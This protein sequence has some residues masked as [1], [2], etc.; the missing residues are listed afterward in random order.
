MRNPSCNGRYRRGRTF[1]KEKG[2]KYSSELTEN[3]LEGKKNFKRKKGGK[4]NSFL[5][6]ERGRVIDCQCVKVNLG[7]GLTMKEGLLRERGGE[8]ISWVVPKHLRRKK[9][10]GPKPGLCPC[11]ENKSRKNN[12][13]KCPVFSKKKA[14]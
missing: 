9:E 2:S 11:I 3:V 4:S 7:Q 5:V 6:V 14:H 10:G 8:K 13:G 1:I 12:Q